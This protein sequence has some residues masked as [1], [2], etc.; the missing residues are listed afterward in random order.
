[1]SLL[2]QIHVASQASD[3]GSIPIARSKNP[4]ETIG[5]ARLSYRNFPQKSP[6]LDARWTPASSFGRF[7]TR[8][9]ERGATVLSS[10]MKGQAE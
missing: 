6:V 9:M 4:D 1:M 7:P 10:V 5:L 2:Q 3:V 8:G